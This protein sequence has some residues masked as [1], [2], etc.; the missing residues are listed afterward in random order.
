MFSYYPGMESSAK[1]AKFFGG[2]P[3]PPPPPAGPLDPWPIKTV[4]SHYF[5][6]GFP[7]LAHALIFY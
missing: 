6:G 5:Q 4:R 2:A 1:I 3:P 7:T